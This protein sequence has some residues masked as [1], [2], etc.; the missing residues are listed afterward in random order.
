MAYVIKRYSNRKLYD[1]QASRYVTLDD[2]EHIIREGKDILVQ[3]S[4]TGEDITSMILTQIVLQTE[5]GGRAALPTAFLHQLIKYGETWQD[6]MAKGLHTTLEGIVS[7]QRETDRIFRAWAAGAGLVPTK[8]RAAPN[9]DA[10]DRPGEAE[11]PRAEVAALREK[12]QALEQALQGKPK[13][14]HRRK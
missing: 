1:V 4:A 7:S 2:L 14:K 3:D 6:V 8:E 12:L 9:A 5:R 11:D 10:R 13:K